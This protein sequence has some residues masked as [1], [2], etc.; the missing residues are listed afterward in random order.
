LFG[1]FEK[2]VGNLDAE[3][4]ASLQDTP[5]IG[6]KYKTQDNKTIYKTGA[7][8]QN[9]LDYSATY[10][11]GMNGGINSGGTLKIPIPAP[12]ITINIS[13]NVNTGTNVNVGKTNVT[14]KMMDIN[15]DGLIDQVL[16]TPGNQVW[17]KLN[18]SGQVGLLRTIRLPQGGRYDL[19]Y[20]RE[21]NTPLM[22]QSRQ[23]LAEVTMTDG[24]PLSVELAAGADPDRGAVAHKYV[25]QYEYEGGYYDREEKEFY[26]FRQVAVIARG[27]ARRTDDLSKQTTIY[28]NEEYYSKGM[29]E[30]RIAY[31]ERGN[32]ASITTN[33]L[34]AP[35][36]RVK[37][38]A[39]RTFDE[40]NPSLEKTTVRTWLYDI[41]DLGKTYGNVVEERDWGEDLNDTGDDLIGRITYWHDESLYLHSHPA[42]IEVKDGL[43]TMLRRREGS[44]SAKGQLVELREYTGLS[45]YLRREYEYDP[46]YGNLI[47][48]RDSVGVT[49]RYEYD[50]IARQYLTEIRQ[51]GSGGTGGTYISR[52][53]WDTALGAKLR[54]IDANGNTVRYRYDSRGRLAAVWTGYDGTTP[55]VAYRYE[56]PKDAPWYAVTANKITFDANDPQVML[57][58]A[59]LDGLGRLRRTAKSGEVYNPSNKQTQYGWNVSGVAEYDGKGRTIREWQPV[60]MAAIPGEAGIGTLLASPQRLERSVK[61]TYD[62][63]DRVTSETLPDGKIQRTIYGIAAEG[64]ERYVYTL[65]TDPLGNKAKQYRDGRE[66]I[67]R[68][69]RLDARGKLLTKATY[70]YN[71]LGEMT[72][73]LDAAGNPLKVVYDLLGRR[74]SLESADSGRT[75]Y[76]YNAKGQLWQERNEELRRQGKRIDYGYDSFGRL[77]K[78]DYPV[79]VDVEY[80]YGGPGAATE[81]LAGRLARVKDESGEIRYEYGKLGEMVRER[82]T[83]LQRTDGLGRSREAVMEYRSDYLGRM[84]AITYPDGETVRYGYDYGGN[85]VSVTGTKQGQA[86]PYVEQ[87]GYDEWGQRVYLKLGNGVE[88]TYTY[89]E[90]RR[91]L[92]RVLTEST[93]QVG[94]PVLQ[95][96]QYNF[97]AVGNVSSYQNNAGT[98][99]TRQEYA[100]DGLYQLVYARGISENRPHGN[101]DYKAEYTQTYQFDTLGLGNMTEKRSWTANTDKRQLGDPLDYEQDYAYAAGFAHRAERIGRRYYQYDLNGN[102]TIEQDGSF[103]AVVSTGGRTITELED[104]TKVVDNGWGMNDNGVAVPA[105]KVWKREYNW[106]ERNLLRT[107]RD[108]QHIVE[109]AYGQDGERSG[110]YSMTADG[111]H[112]SETLYFNKLWVWHYDGLLNEFT[113]RNSKHIYLSESRIVTKISRADGGSTA[114]ERIKQYYYHNDH[115]GSAQ[116]ISNADGQ[117]YERIEYTPYGELWIEKASTASNIDIPYRFTGKERDEE[118][119]LYYYG[120]R[121]LDSKASRW[122]STDPAVGDYIPGAPV[123]D[124]AKKRNQ[125]LPGMGGVFNTVNLHLYHYAGNNPVKYVD[126]DGKILEDVDGTGFQQN[127]NQQLGTENTTIAQQGCVLM[128][129]TRIANAISGNSYTLE[130]ANQVAI[131]NSLYSGEGGDLTVEN[132]AAL[133][134]L[135]TGENINYHTVSGDMSNAIIPEL[136]DINSSDKSYYATGRMLTTDSNGSYSQNNNGQFSA[137]HTVNIRSVAS[138]S[139]ITV[140]DTSNVNRTTTNGHI[141]AIPSGAL[142][143]EPINSIHIFSVRE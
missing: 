97:D 9:E 122:L 94:K 140:R 129:I 118:T 110:K 61:K 47:L 141:I 3:S 30:E 101:L 44:Y 2:T 15:G 63:L 62:G 51:E 67:V 76:T 24:R 117:E 90:D 79:S 106:N 31:N 98:Y 93:G 18:R 45:A 6:S 124:E 26:G 64:Q 13:G 113:G 78:I 40:E 12:V 54:E 14:V 10:S 35:Y 133:I 72:L 4:L 22:P 52:L 120:A 86:F 139:E 134:G 104:G 103:G 57:T 143:Q 71:A 1:E 29:E 60:F 142:L 59:E 126:P 66:N 50:G 128:A 99:N 96:I 46:V 84:Q 34:D 112:Q 114:E 83:I 77:T 8:K 75:D 138:Q 49:L 17:A 41:N 68:V 119:G 121:Y 58:V 5:V 136:N 39:T 23:V 137:N 33:T 116:V 81:N 48:A 16:R 73:A 27:D 19:S 125:S 108:D 43:G 132:Q 65:A 70:R 111:G 87:I 55:A 53:E 127:S 85:V 88:T 130:Q 109:Y 25:T 7:L 42:S 102:V 80:E 92:S 37:M 36:P 28:F 20:R 38:S 56:T 135:L 32:P 89:N 95:D 115:L 82:R 69:E 74:I 107:S 91:W 11:Q 100:Y 105:S 123:D 131:N 21:G